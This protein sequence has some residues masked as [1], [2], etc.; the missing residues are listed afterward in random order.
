MHPAYLAGPAPDFHP[1]EWVTGEWAWKIDKHLPFSSY[2]AWS[3]DRRFWL[4]EALA[5]PD[6]WWRITAVREP[7]GPT[8][9]DTAARSG[10]EHPALRT[11]T[12]CRSLLGILSGAGWRSVYRDGALVVESPDL[13]ARVRVRVDPPGDPLDLGDPHI[14]VEAGP[15]G[16]S[17][18]P[19]YWQAKVSAGAPTVITDALAR[20]LT[21]PD[22][23]TRDARRMDKRLLS[24]LARLDPPA[25][26]QPASRITPPATTIA[27][28]VAAA[29]SRTTKPILAA[30][31]AADGAAPAEA[32][33]PPMGRPA[34]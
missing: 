4:G 6:D 8:D 10:E 20:T 9:R 26:E 27:Q 19:P 13:L 12:D 23:V 28:R 32:A 15:R 31:A 33:S 2:L 3:P 25:P 14:H 24:T 29:A 11:P 22:P 16:R 5:D 1:F 30:A 17:G 34:R 18:Q 21:S 7:L